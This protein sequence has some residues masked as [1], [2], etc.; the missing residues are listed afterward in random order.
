[1]KKHA[2]FLFVLLFS[3]FAQAEL[4]MAVEDRGMDGEARIYSVRCPDDR[5]LGIEHWFQKNRICFVPLS[6]KEICME[7][8]DIDLAAQQACALSKRKK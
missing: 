8:N 3:G 7:T 6:R 5:R 1:M 4:P 2:L